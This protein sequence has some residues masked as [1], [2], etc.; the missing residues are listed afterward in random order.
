[1]KGKSEINLVTPGQGISLM[2]VVVESLGDWGEEAVR[3]VR[4]LA[5]VLARHTGQDV[6]RF[7]WGRLAL[8]LQRD[9]AA[10]LG[11][12]IPTYPSMAST[13]VKAKHLSDS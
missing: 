1:M 12:R 13:R 6:L 9:N 3:V 2:P 8:C 10:I 5:G 4:R 7:Q 11:N